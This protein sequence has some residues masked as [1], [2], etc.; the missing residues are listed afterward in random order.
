[1]I[2]TQLFAFSGYTKGRFEITDIQKIDQNYLVDIKLPYVFKEKLLKKKKYF[3][4]ELYVEINGIPA[5]IIETSEDTEFLYIHSKISDTLYESATIKDLKVK[6]KV[7]IGLQSLNE[8]KYLIENR[9]LGRAK[10]IN[11]E[12]K[13]DDESIQEL[14]FETSANLINM[15]SENEWL[16]LNGS[17]F[18]IKQYEMVNDKIKFKIEVWPE[19]REKTI[20]GTTEME[21]GQEYNVSSAFK[22]EKSNLTLK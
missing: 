1:M 5:F 21:I 2:G 12:K 8:K 3:E 17:S 6:D 16:G 19:T 14:F 4:S 20:F 10:L 22:K 13:P 7:S 18:F 15:I 11:F 9:P